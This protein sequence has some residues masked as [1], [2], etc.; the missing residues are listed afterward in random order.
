MRGPASTSPLVLPVA[1]WNSSHAA[2]DLQV[3][4]VQCPGLQESDLVGV[5]HITGQADVGDHEI[6]VR[7][8][9]RCRT[10]EICGRSLDEFENELVAPIHLLIHRKGLKTEIVWNDETDESFE[11]SIPGDLRELDI[12]EIVRQVIELERPISPIKPGIA[13][14]EGVEP[15][16]VPLPEPEA[17]AIDP[18]WAA[19]AKLKDKTS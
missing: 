13:L 15:E 11:V 12:E 8:E 3:D 19:L 14:P 4:A 16:D 2:I 7:I 9:V 6:V 5:V 1:R 17:P 10:R 18:R